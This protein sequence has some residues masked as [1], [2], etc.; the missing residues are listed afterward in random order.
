MIDNTT[1]LSTPEAQPTATDPEK[2][3]R[4]GRKAPQETEA[5][6]PTTRDPEKATEGKEQTK[7]AS[8]TMTK[9]KKMNANY[10]E[11]ESKP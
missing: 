9:N 8:E 2:E 11:H 5:E 1:R 3:P 7:E 6:E 10:Q 4:T